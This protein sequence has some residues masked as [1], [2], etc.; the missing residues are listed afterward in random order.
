MN[1]ISTILSFIVILLCCIL[2]F[3]WHAGFSPFGPTSYTALSD[4]AKQ[5]PSLL[6][7]DT[8]TAIA[9][10]HGK[11]T[12]QVLLRWSV[13]R[14]VVVVPKSVSQDRLKQNIDV[15]GFALDEADM[16]ALDALEAGKRFNDPGV[17]ANYPIWN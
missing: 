10:K 12:G 2:F 14:D 16:K 6:A 4:D 8:V 11:S 15:F 9:A 1:T 3:S 7:H 5:Y 13:Q 17:F